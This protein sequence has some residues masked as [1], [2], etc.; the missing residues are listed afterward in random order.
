MEGARGGRGVACKSSRRFRAD[1]PRNFADGRQPTPRTEDGSPAARS[2]VC[3]C[4]CV[5]VSA[6]LHENLAVANLRDDADDVD[7]RWILQHHTTSAAVTAVYGSHK[8][9]FFLLFFF[10]FF[11]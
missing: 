9:S 6:Y 3:V 11:F 2:T 5:Y 7:A 8:A 4:V 10:S 1:R